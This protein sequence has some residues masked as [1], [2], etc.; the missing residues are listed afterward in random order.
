MKMKF[1]CVFIYPQMRVL[2]NW[3]KCMWTYAFHTT[4]YNHKYRWEQI[5]I[6]ILCAC[7][8]FYWQTQEDSNFMHTKTQNEHQ[9]FEY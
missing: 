1:S 3:S 4:K 9:V 2:A 7:E 6:M 5:N 8:I